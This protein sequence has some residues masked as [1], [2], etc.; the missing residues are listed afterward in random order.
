MLIIRL[1]R[2]LSTFVT[3]SQPLCC[4]F[5]T[6]FLH[7]TSPSY[8]GLATLSLKVLSASTPYGSTCVLSLLILE[9]RDIT[10]FGFFTAMLFL[11]ETKALSL[12]ELDQ[13]LSVPTHVHASYQLKALP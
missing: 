8:S 11:P 10:L 2:S 7:S 6:S 3:P 4:G 5:S 13:V 1:K 9:D 12:E